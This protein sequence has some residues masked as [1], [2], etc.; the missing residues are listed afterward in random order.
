MV[1]ILENFCNFYFAVTVA[2]TWGG[3]YTNVERAVPDIN[4]E[5]DRYMQYIVDQIT[6][7]QCEGYIVRLYERRGVNMGKW[8]QLASNWLKGTEFH[9]RGGVFR[10]IYGSYVIYQFSFAHV[11]E[12]NY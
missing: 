3:M 7:M 4:T 1:C 8:T 6:T 2:Y 9:R 10:Q 12:L 11:L 5:T